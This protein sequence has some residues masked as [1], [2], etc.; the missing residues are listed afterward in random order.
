MDAATSAATTASPSPLKRRRANDSDGCDPSAWAPSVPTSNSGGT[1]TLT[2]APAA[3]T[4]SRGA[5]GSGAGARLRLSVSAIQARK[6]ERRSER[7]GPSRS[8]MHWATSRCVPSGPRDRAAASS[9]SEN[10]AAVANR[11]RDRDRA[12]SCRL[13]QSLVERRARRFS[14]KGSARIKAGSA[15][16]PPRR[17]GRDAGERASPTRQIPMAKMSARRS[18]FSDR[19]C[20]GAMYA[21]LPLSCPVRVTAR[22]EAARAMPKSVIFETPST[23]TR[24]L[25]GETSR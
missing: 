13:R 2:M 11:S 8:A 15:S 24:M 17:P 22:R 4:S 23:L 19:A 9:A 25:C 14:A 12:P 3:P 7:S 5:S 20:S 1:Y 16:R 10:S 6:P 21:I 18:I